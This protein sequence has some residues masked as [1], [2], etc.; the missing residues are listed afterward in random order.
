MHTQRTINLIP[1]FLIS[2]CALSVAEVKTGEKTESYRTC[3]LKYAGFVGKWT[4]EGWDT[5]ELTAASAKALISDR[6]RMRRIMGR[7]LR[8]QLSVD[9]DTPVRRAF[10]FFV[11]KASRLTPGQRLKLFCAFIEEIKK[12]FPAWVANGPFPIADGGQLFLGRA[13]SVLIFR[14]DGEFFIGEVDRGFL[15]GVG[16]LQNWA[17]RYGDFQTLKAFLES[18]DKAYLES[19]SEAS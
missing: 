14:G 16:P 5:P 10:T 9:S 8:G 1:F 2:F 18:R 3:A 4:K 6:P 12:R 13:G 11:A 19:L 15:F 17:P 7:V